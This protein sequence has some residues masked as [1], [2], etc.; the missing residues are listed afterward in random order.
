MMR[1]VRILPIISLIGFI[2]LIIS[3]EDDKS[4]NPQDQA[5][6]VPPQ[7]TMIID[8]SEFPDTSTEDG[9]QNVVIAIAA[10]KSYEENRPVKISE[11]QS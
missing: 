6:T 2:T 9:F 10:Q 8:F 4:T 5:P 3:C 7:S 11:I 1:F